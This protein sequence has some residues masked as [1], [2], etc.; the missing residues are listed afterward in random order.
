MSEKQNTFSGKSKKE[1]KK[2]I[3]DLQRM[4]KPQ[5]IEAEEAILG[6]I[7]LYNESLYQVL[8]LLDTTD[9]YRKKNGYIYGA[10]VQ[11]EEQNEPIDPISLANQLKLNG[12][13]EEVGGL[14]YLTELADRVPT[15]ANVYYYGKILRDKALLRQIIDVGTE[16]VKEAYDEVGDVPAFLDGA[17]KRIFDIR[18]GRSNKALVPI[19]AIIADAFKA[20]EQLYQR[21]SLVTGTPS[22]LD[23]L[24]KMTSGFHPSDLVIL[25]G[26]PS[27]GKTALAIS[28]AVNAGLHNDCVVAI[29]S[30]EMSKEQLVIRI[31]C[32]ESRVDASR[33]RTGMMEAGDVPKL[34]DTA[35]KLNNARIYIDDTPAASVLDIRAKCRRLKMEHDRLD[36]VVIDYLQLAKSGMKALDSREREIS[37]ISMGLK[38]MAKELHTPVMALSQLNRSLERRPDKR[39]IMSDLRESGAIEQ[40]ADLIMFVYRDEV[41]NK[42]TEEKGVA[43][44]IIG[45]QRS[46]PVGTVKVKFFHQYTRFDNLYPEQ[47]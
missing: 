18:E 22:G 38:S 37:E 33:L 34:T 26:R 2:S 25:A 17:E 31:L 1:G 21:Q 40:D 28:M 35:S 16:V 29:F 5:S 43:E 8:P 11:L 27:M 44:V 23:E 3:Q 10:A 39:P 13:L 30:L 15:A 45:K 4:V 47:A 20:V 46:G 19:N 24:D 32:S 14:P 12:H 42:E 41:Y 36:L 6:S 9:F 7:M